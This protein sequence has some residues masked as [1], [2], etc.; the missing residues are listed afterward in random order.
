MVL[1]T[2]CFYRFRYVQLQSSLFTDQR[3]RW[4]HPNDVERV[5]D[6]LRKETVSGQDLLYQTYDEIVQRNT[7]DKEEMPNKHRHAAKLYSVVLAAFIPLTTAMLVEYLAHDLE[8]SHRDR[9]ITKEY[10][11]DLSRDI[12]VPVRK[13]CFK[14]ITFDFAH[15]SV[16]EYLER[17]EEHARSKIHWDM[18]SR[19]K[20][21]SR[22]SRNLRSLTDV[23][24]EEDHH[25]HDSMGLYFFAMWAPHMMHLLQ[26][27][28]AR[29]TLL[30]IAH[31][32]FPNAVK[33]WLEAISSVQNEIYNTVGPR[34]G[35]ADRGQL[36]SKFPPFRCPLDML[37]NGYKNLK[38]L[39]SFED[40]KQVIIAEAEKIRDA[41]GSVDLTETPQRI[42]AKEDNH[43][44]MPHPTPEILSALKILE[45][46]ADW[47]LNL[48]TTI[49]RTSN[50]AH[51]IRRETFQPIAMPLLT[52]IEQARGL[53]DPNTPSEEERVTVCQAVVKRI[54]NERPFLLSSPHWFKI[55]AN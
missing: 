37:I 13:E 21:I 24:L 8:T 42:M 27:N 4:T 20:L 16:K 53:Q 25:V 48:L 32:D 2:H 29:D 3:K 26:S 6:R 15:I 46:A 14:G 54:V 52:V 10:L 5:I 41:L 45:N 49:C 28:N 19:M 18:I 31:I 22:S 36:L 23:L 1:D 12:L 11:E 43:K 40:M 30:V 33:N 9:T 35:C 47:T 17:Q 38:P 50:F 34:I 51:R 39:P 55:N 7:G 44:W